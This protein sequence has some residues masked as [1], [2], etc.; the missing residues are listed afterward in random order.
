MNAARESY[1]SFAFPSYSSYPSSFFFPHQ[2]LQVNFWLKFIMKLKIFIR[3]KNAKKE[4]IKPMQ[5]SIKLSNLVLIC[6]KIFPSPSPFPLFCFHKKKSVLFFQDFFRFDDWK[7][8]K[9]FFHNLYNFLHREVEKD[10]KLQNQG[11]WE[12]GVRKEESRRKL[13]DLRFILIFDKMIRLLGEKL[14]FYLNR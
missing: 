12:N 3:R 9:K 11:G 13:F 14:K 10:K 1:F 5:C 8:E 2:I 4:F 6:L 7:T